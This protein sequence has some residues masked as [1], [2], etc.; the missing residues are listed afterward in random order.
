MTE[1]SKDEGVITV[2][3]Q[4]LEQQRLPRLL[5]FKEKVE[6][7]EQLNDFD[8]E[9]LSEVLA[10]AEKV[11]PLVE[12]HPEYADMVTKMVSLYKE[13]TEKA[14]ENEKKT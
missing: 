2:L 12:R 14:L 11:G 5:D 13:I 3:L 10:D 9:Y 4:R 7:G 8:I 6:N 1:D